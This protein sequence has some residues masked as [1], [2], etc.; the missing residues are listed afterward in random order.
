[1]NNNNFFMTTKPINRVKNDNMW[2]KDL[3]I[4]PVDKEQYDGKEEDEQTTHT[5]H[6]TKRIEVNRNERHNLIS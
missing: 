1:M 4:I 3:G 2:T 5:D 6:H